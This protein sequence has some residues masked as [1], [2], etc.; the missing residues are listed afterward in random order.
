MNRCYQELADYYKTALLPG[1]SLSPKDKVG[2][3]S[4]WKTNFTSSHNYET[5][6]ASSIRWTEYRS[7][8]T[9][10][11]LQPQRFPKASRYSGST[12][13]EILF[14]QSL[15]G[16]PYEFSLWKTATV[17]LNY[18]I[19]FDNRVL[20]GSLCICQKESRYPQCEESCWGLLSEYQSIQP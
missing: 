7:T 8:K 9:S 3:R 12:N 19:A 5:E 6:D 10:G 18:H 13:E 4:S 2:R 11:C 20:F 15:P 17:Q 14:M 16:I 1:K